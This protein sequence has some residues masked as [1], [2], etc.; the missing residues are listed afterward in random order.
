MNEPKKVIETDRL[1]LREMTD[2]DLDVLFHIFSDE[3]TMKFYP[4]VFS[5]EEAADWIDWNRKSYPRNGFGLW[6]VIL[7]ENGAC[8]GD[9]GI[10]RQEIDGEIYPEIG[11]HI[12]KEYQRKGYASEAARACRDFGFNALK[13]TSIVSYMDVRNIPSRKTAEKIGMRFVKEFKKVVMGMEAAEALYQIDRA[14]IRATE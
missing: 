13:L 11:Y 8:I 6:A 2:D 10:T 4:R 3:E 9:C 12:A 14:D 1:Y 5:R 7:K